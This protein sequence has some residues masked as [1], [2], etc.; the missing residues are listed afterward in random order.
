MKSRLLFVVR[1]LPYESSGTPVVIRNLLMHLPADDFFVLGRTPHP[2]KRLPNTVKQKMFEIPILHTKG[3]RFWKY[4]SILPGFVMGIWMIKKYK[5]NKIIG[6]F[7]DDASLLL[8]YLLALLFPKLEFYPYLMDLYAEQKE[9][10][11]R[12]QNLQ[13]AIFKRA[14][15]ILLVNDGMNE[16][17]NSRY[18]NLNFKT[19]PI[20]SQ[21]GTKQPIDS[22]KNLKE[23]SKKFM[24]VFSGSVNEDRLETLRI[25]TKIISQDS[26]I[27]MR[28]L[29]SQ[30]QETLEKLGV[31]YDGFH[32]RYCKTP[33][34]LIQ[35]L[36]K[37]DILYLPL[38]FSYP[39]AKKPQ[40]ITC[41]GAK[42]FDYMQ[43][44]VPILIHAPHDVFN[45]T[46]FEK[47]KAAFLLN[48][49]EEDTI[50]NKLDILLQEAGKETSKQLVMNAN[51]LAKQFDGEIVSQ[52][53]LKTIQH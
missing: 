33:E 24:L 5:I 23:P 36:N 48:S 49:L 12:V 17:L 22:T 43:A 27:T 7:Q 28:Y 8:A 15:K 29:T 37:A 9:D 52:L 19:I 45:Y 42:V 6:V 25:M 13:N 51:T 18:P 1:A 31:F 16:Y 4:Y 41:F 14:K 11:S 47:N 2:Q 53:F 50:K 35:E 32:V 21:I 38:A 40:M 30:S 3:H 10:N 39:E 26:R 20:I 34:E 46:F 44:S